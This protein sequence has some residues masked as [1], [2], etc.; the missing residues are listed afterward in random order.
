MQKR[1]E[2]NRSYHIDM[3]E[4]GG[5]IGKMGKWENGKMGKGERGKR[6]GEGRGKSGDE[7]EKGDKAD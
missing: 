7:G 2:Q 1:M 3:T 4:I 5:V 6:G